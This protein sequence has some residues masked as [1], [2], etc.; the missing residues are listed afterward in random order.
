MR[1]TIRRQRLRRQGLRGQGLGLGTLALVALLPLA[2]QARNTEVILPAEKAVT[3]PHGKK[4]LLDVP[5]FF[6]GQADA[7]RGKVLSTV[8]T[9]Q[10]SRGAFRSDE[11]S[12]RVAF[13][14]ALRELQ[15]RARSGGGDAVVDIVSVTRDVRTESPT[16]Y[17]CGA[18]AMIVHVALEGTIVE[19][20]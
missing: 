5:V 14:T 13:L 19:L 2:G 10:A 17:R 7:P 6:K 11:A 20:D 4:Y 3:S 1:R 12:C 9:E 8:T 18:G 15:E 16:N